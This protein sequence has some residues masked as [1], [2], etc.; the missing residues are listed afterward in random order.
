MQVEAV[1]PCQC[2]SL[3][4]MVTVSPGRIRV[5]PPA[6]LATRPTP[7]VTYRVWPR[8]WLCQK[9]RAPGVKRT[10]APVSRAG[11]TAGASGVT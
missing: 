11:S 9:V 7:S 3:A 5:A 2:S 4:P 8:S 6:R 1:P 10:R